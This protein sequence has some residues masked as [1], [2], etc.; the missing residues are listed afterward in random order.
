MA[1][2]PCDCLTPDGVLSS[3][4]SLAGRNGAYPYASL[5]QTT[6]GSLYGTASYGG[7]GFNGASSSGNG[8]LFRVAFGPVPRVPS[9][10]SQPANRIVAAGGTATF[11]VAAAGTPAPRYYWR[12]N[13]T[14]IGGATVSI[15]SLP[16]VQVGDSGAQFSC[17]VS[18]VEGSVVSSN[19]LLTV[20]PAGTSGCI[21]QFS[22]TDGGYPSSSLLQGPD[23]NFY[24]TTR[25]G[26]ANNYG[27]V[28]RITPNGVRTVLRSFD[29][30]D[31][32]FPEAGL[33]QGADGG[34][35]GTTLSGGTN[36]SGTL[37]RV[38]MA[39]DFSSW[40]PF[41]YGTPR[42][43]RDNLV[44]GRD[45]KLYGSASYGAQNYY[46]AVFS[47]TTNGILNTLF[48]FGGTN[49]S[50]PRGLIQLANGELFGVTT[51]GGAFGYGTVFRLTTNGV[52]SLL[53]SFRQDTN[54]YYPGGALVLGPDLALY[55]T[56]SRG[57][58]YG[59]G[60]IFRLTTNG[61]WTRWFSL[62]YSEGGSPQSG[63]ILGR[64]GAFYGTAS[65]GG[66]N[67]AGT[68]Y[69]MTSRGPTNLFSFAGTNGAYPTASLVQA[70]DGNLYGTCMY[71][72]WGFNGGGYESGNGAVFRTLPPAVGTNVAHFVWDAIPSPQLANEPFQVRIR[73]FTDTDRLVTNFNG[74]VI[75]R[76]WS[77]G[78]LV[79]VS[80]GTS[81]HFARGEWNGVVTVTEAAIDLV[82][83]ADD[84]S[85][86]R[87]LSNP[88]EV[89]TAGPPLQVGYSG[90]TM[91]L[92]WPAS[93]LG[94]V[95]EVSPSLSPP[96]W[97]RAP[98]RPIIIGDQS[99]VPVQM[100]ERSAFY[101]LRFIRP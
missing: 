99:V 52:F 29:S 87:G 94:F 85:G 68:V 46:G 65:Y 28:F 41:T 35:Y 62:T 12:R 89:I 6:D 21:F 9:L 4:F 75:L 56:A 30:T 19:A 17:L 14:P 39:G 96:Q 97:T 44:L 54:G 55:G 78:N 90:S 37:F 72:G 86:H 23:G 69:R 79:P 77:H 50:Y 98:D 64:D 22:G 60:T 40:C 3:L 42:Y 16:N 58:D 43:C 49:G 13:G 31:G 73:A 25:F 2:E 101:R 100:V 84:G 80:P 26:G 88:I 1:T 93:P 36:G 66:N 27:T 11:S 47:L 57:G 71:G 45:G 91:L 34:F 95:L 74:T 24:G 51:Y 48:T 32:A 8:T 15:Y 83:E 81:G 53:Y 67:G 7:M 63:L 5:V 76:G 33:V 59:G 61:L 18:N 70:S 92:F 38:T 20:Q 10:V 82:L